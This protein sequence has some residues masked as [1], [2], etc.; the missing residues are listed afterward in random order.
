MNSSN[1]REENAQKSSVVPDQAR[2]SFSARE[3]SVRIALIVGILL[4][5]VLSFWLLL[6]LQEAPPKS[7]KAT[8][9][10]PV[11]VERISPVD[12]TS[13]VRGVGTVAPRHLVRIRPEV[14]G[15]IVE[16]HP[17][18]L[19]GAVVQQGDLLFRIDPRNYELAIE[20]A[21]AQLERA[22]FELT[23]EKGNQ[24]VAKREWAL[25][26]DLGVDTSYAE[27]HRS[28][29]L[30]KP[31]LQ[32]KLAQVSAA[33]SRLQRAQLDLER[34]EVIA[35][36]D[37]TILRKNLEVGG[38][39]SPQETVLEI[40]GTQQFEIEV[41]I[42]RSELRWLTR[43][44]LGVASDREEKLNY[45]TKILQRIGNGRYQHHEGM[46][47]RLVGEVQRDGRMARVLVTVDK[48]LGR[49][50]T[51][52]FPLLIGTA[53]EVVIDGD[54]ILH[55]YPIPVRAIREGEVI[56][57]V[58]EEN[59]LETLSVE[60]IFSTSDFMYVRGEFAQEITLVTSALSNPLEGLLLA[61]PEEVAEEEPLNVSEAEATTIIPEMGE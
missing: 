19:V 18:L 5:G 16:M 24:S 14:S 50:S 3:L 25:L 60:P 59:T 8:S 6:S 57:T 45:E 17:D 34:T 37:G 55:V 13:Q 20:E 39:T 35:P 31:H 11:M 29:A 61:I 44:Y 26:K 30:R 36:F 58:S 46:A 2:T 12:V 53:V 43:L 21:R 42:P 27:T 1:E 54:Q 49:D 40:A 32:E 48:P 15:Q 52:S 38:Y 56:W 47:E 51:P 4:L 23:L 7:T 10:T 41:E 9:A 28:L 22:S 33:K